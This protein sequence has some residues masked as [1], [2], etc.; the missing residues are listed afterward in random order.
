M[1]GQN[2]DYFKNRVTLGGV[3]LSPDDQGEILAGYSMPLGLVVR[4]NPIGGQRTGPKTFEPD[5]YL[6]IESEGVRLTL[7]GLWEKQG[8]NGEYLTGAFG[9]VKV[10]GLPNDRAGQPS[11]NGHGIEPDYEIF[12]LP[13]ANSQGQG[14]TVKP[15]QDAAQRRPSLPKHKGPT[16]S[17]TDNRTAQFSPT[18]KPHPP[19][20]RQALALVMESGNKRE[21]Q[22]LMSNPETAGQMLLRLKE[23][24]SS[25]TRAQVEAW[26]AERVRQD[27]VPTT[28]AQPAKPKPARKPRKAKAKKPKVAGPII[29]PDLNDR[30][31]DLPA[32]GGPEK[33]KAKMKTPKKKPTAKRDLIQITPENYA[34]AG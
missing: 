22:Q 33:V 6:Y 32:F 12:G 9:G 20:Y 30:I 13:K 18:G 21:L 2:N 17:R 11:S 26:Q 1:A 4:P 7:C 3:S 16:Y 8:A 25:G 23:Q 28:P 24:Q 31:D 34:Q 10:L 14:T 5:Y 27:Y 15:R 19:E 29:D